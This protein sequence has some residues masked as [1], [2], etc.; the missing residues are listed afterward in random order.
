MRLQS[1]PPAGAGTGGGPACVPVAAAA[2]RASSG[3]WTAGAA[4][5][6]RCRALAVPC[7]PPPVPAPSRL[8][9]SSPVKYESTVKS[10]HY[11][12]PFEGRKDPDEVGGVTT[13]QAPTTIPA[14]LATQPLLTCSRLLGSSLPLKRHPRGP[15]NVPRQGGPGD[16]PRCDLINST[17][18]SSHTC[19]FTVLSQLISVRKSVLYQM[20]KNTKHRTL[21]RNEWCAIL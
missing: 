7:R 5:G 8:L 3:A 19:V 12:S 4:A 15:W 1:R 2:A 13:Q 18:S 10:K 6:T 16:R 14:L 20:E 21:P 11:P 9:A 17:S